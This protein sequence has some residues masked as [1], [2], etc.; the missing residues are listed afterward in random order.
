MIRAI[1]RDVS[2]TI[3]NCELGFIERK[4]I[5]FA[6]TVQQLEGYRQALRRCGVEVTCLP[7][8]QSHP[9]ACFVED[10]AIVLDDV[11]VICNPGALSRR[12][13]TPPI[14]SELAKYRELTY[15]QS[16]GTIDGGDVLIA[17]TRILVG[18]SNRTNDDGIGMLARIA[19]QFGYTLTVVDV[20]GCL[21]FKSACTAINDETL[22]VN[23]AWVDPAALSGFHLIDVPRD[24]PWSAN[25]LRVEDTVFVQA[26][27]PR[28]LDRIREVHKCVESLD[29][30]EFRKAE[31]SLT[32]LSL[33]F[34]DHN[35]G[36]LR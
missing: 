25:I 30:S 18:R 29:V 34:K 33:I 9:D 35:V 22:L 3:E 16:P 32:C 27:F 20:T 17:G 12:G 10:T 5:D 19:V 14:A 21:H 31:A 15:I 7:E 2:K 24:E 36:A 26:D 11:A 13:E 1:T 28:T 8:D 23:A 4:P 6:R